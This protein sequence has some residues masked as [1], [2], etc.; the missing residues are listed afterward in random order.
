MEARYQCNADDYLEAQRAQIGTSR[1]IIWLLCMLAV[2]VAVLEVRAIGFAKAAP[3]LLCVGLLLSYPF[4]FFASR[5]KH[6]FRRHPHLAREYHLLADD[7]RLIMS[8]DASESGGKWTTFSSFRETPNLFL[9]Y[10]GARTF[11]MVPKRGFAGGEA[12][13]FRE[14]LRRKL[15]SK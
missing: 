2:P 6:D 11:F 9:V 5:V 10:R 14:L 15:R 3:V 7:E 13:E 8:S 4:L 12:D 1:R